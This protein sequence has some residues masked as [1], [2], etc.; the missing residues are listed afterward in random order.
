MIKNYLVFHLLPCGLERGSA[1]SEFRAGGPRLPDGVHLVLGE[2]DHSVPDNPHS[3]LQPHCRPAYLVFPVRSIW[4][5]PNPIS[6]SARSVN[7][8]LSPSASLAN[9][10]QFDATSTPDAK[11][12]K[13]PYLLISRILSECSQH[14]GHLRVRGSMSQS[15]LPITWILVIS[16][17]S[18]QISMSSVSG[19]ASSSPRWAVYPA[20]VSMH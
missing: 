7:P 14:V 17:I 11:D 5:R 1:E 4:S 19:D 2:H 20:A 13:L 16:G 9:R 6:S 15:P 12:Q 10:S 3:A 18:A 8:A